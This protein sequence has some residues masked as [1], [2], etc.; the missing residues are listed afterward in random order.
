MA[1]GDPRGIGRDEIA[2][3]RT[4]VEDIP[5]EGWI[6]VSG[7]EG[8]AESAATCRAE[9]QSGPEAVGVVCKGMRERRLVATQSVATVVQLAR[10]CDGGG[11]GNGCREDQR[12]D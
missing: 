9:C 8:L 3:E 10:A 2:S 12:S 1:G 5:N 11:F 4:Q 7:A 6:D